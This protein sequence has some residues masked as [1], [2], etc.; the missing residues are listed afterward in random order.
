MLL[1]PVSIIMANDYDNQLFLPGSANVKTSVLQEDDQA[2]IATLDSTPTFLLHLE[3]TTE[4]EIHVE[5]YGFDNLGGSGIKDYDVQYK[6]QYM[7]NDPHTLIAPMWIDLYINTT[8]TVDHF[9]ATTDHV[10]YFR[11]RACDNAGNEEPWTE[12]FNSITV[13]KRI[14]NETYEEAIEQ[15]RNGNL[16]DDIPSEIKDRLKEPKKPKD[17]KEPGD[18]IPP[19]SKV[20]P[21]FPVHIC[22]PECYWIAEKETVT[23][24]V[25]PEPPIHYVIDWLEERGIVSQTSGLPNFD[26]SWFGFDVPMENGSGIEAYDIQYR[27]VYVYT[28]VFIKETPPGTGLRINTKWD[29]WVTDTTDTQATFFTDAGGGLYQFRC[30]AKDF[31]GNNEEYPLNADTSIYVINLGKVETK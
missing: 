11:V 19:I 7:G 30:K 3:D 29:D 8:E 10:Y 27:K 4:L 23:L 22:M 20:T 28:L 17:P 2:P 15:I 25:Y 6:K 12:L 14:P 9:F 1:T 26:V 18:I 31:A 24:Q 5:W 13:V 16:D 21:L